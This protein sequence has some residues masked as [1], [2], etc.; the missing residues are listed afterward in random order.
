MEG[1]KTELSQEDSGGI[2]KLRRK[3]ESEKRR[4][5]L[6]VPGA[7]VLAV[8]AAIAIIVVAGPAADDSSLV[9][10]TPSLKP[11]PAKD[12]VTRFTVS[13]S[14]DLLIHSP[15]WLDALANGGGEYDFG[16]M[17]EPIR[18][19]IKGPALSICHVETPITTGEPSGF[20]I[21]SA[22]SALAGAIR[23]AGWR[24]CNTASNHSVD[25]AQVGIDETGEL[26]DQAGVA[27][28]GSF[29]S[30]RDQ[31]R[32]TIIR[33][34]R[35]KVGLL[36][37]TDATNGLPLPSPWSVNVLPAAEP[38]ATKARIVARDARRLK[39]AGA[40]AILVNMQW[41][42]ENS[43]SPNT[44]QRELARAI[45]SIDEVD[46]IAGQGPHVVQPIER[47]GGK[48]V[49]FSAGNLLS[50]QGAHS[51]LP[52][53]TQDGLIALFRFRLQKGQSEVERI[54]YVPVWVTPYGHEILPAGLAGRS[55]PDYAADLAASWQR[56]VDTAGI[57]GRIK[58]VP[59]KPRS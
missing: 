26:L 37:Y 58:P 24:A 17:F 10:A 44:A 23:K 56:T 32:T 16:P 33:A 7:V 38:A 40:D 59:R 14:G 41:G 50:N 35:A 3:L 15:V 8:A 39:S 22:P 27:H 51:G 43:T 28:T 47:I 49:V 25:Q 42:D 20:P 1:W 4:N 48:F 29:S 9:V 21:F 54:D 5:R 36:A 53:G 52:V 57:G 19:F 11:T 34:G 13:T 6:W 31:K 2:P 18:R 30:A 46:A 55:H 45:L 12:P